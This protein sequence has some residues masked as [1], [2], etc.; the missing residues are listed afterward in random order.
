EGGTQT[1]HKVNILGF[2]DH[3]RGHIK[4]YAD[5][6]ERHQ[7]GSSF[8]ICYDVETA[9]SYVWRRMPD[10]FGTKRHWT[11]EDELDNS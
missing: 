6:V 4:T 7:L 8:P 3:I 5:R 11:K 10:G 9:I 1:I 2:Q